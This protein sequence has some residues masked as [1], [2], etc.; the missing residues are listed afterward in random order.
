[1]TDNTVTIDGQ[2][3]VFAVMLVNPEFRVPIPYGKIL[4]LTIIESIYSTFPIGK[5]TIDNTHELIENYTEP[6]MNQKSKN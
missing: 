1:M 5:I 6:V 3:Y 4:D 2:D